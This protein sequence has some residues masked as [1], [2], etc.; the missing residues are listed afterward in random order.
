MFR[1][2]RERSLLGYV[3]LRLAAAV[4]VLFALLLAVALVVGMQFERHV[5]LSAGGVPPAELGG[6]GPPAGLAWRDLLK[7]VAALLALAAFAILLF[8]TFEN[9]RSITQ[10]FERVKHLMRNV[11][12][13][14]PTGVLTLDPRGTVTSLNSAAERLLGVRASAVVG[15]PVD[16]VLRA[17]PE[18][19]AWIRTALG[20]HG[21]VQESDLSLTGDGSRRMTLRLSASELRDESAR[22]DGLVVLIRDITEV[23]RLELQLRRADKLAALG[24]LAAGVAHEVKNPLHALS[25]N[26]HLL[27]Q[28]LEAPQPSKPE[29]KVYLDILRSEIQRI[30]RIVENFLRF[31]KPSIPEIKPLDLNALAERVLSLVA[32]EAADHGVTIETEFDPAL[33]SVPA[34]EG[35]LAQVVLNLVINGLQAMPSGGVLTL[36]TR[37]QK[38]WAELTVRDSGGGIRPE[39]LPQI[40]DPY[41]T[42]RPGGVGLGLAIAH[43]IIEGHSGTI[44][45]ESK[46]GEGTVIIV[47]LPLAGV[48]AREVG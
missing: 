48:G 22:S 26:L 30:H 38:E 36:A 4:F 42:T 25:L 45:V 18:V 31:A 23:S 14:I 11:L 47:R 24:T 29:L 16:E 6:Q 27:A 37:R 2:A 46:A 10:T 20:G 15:R 7:V 17:A 41:F 8:T 40:F 34:D 28:E 3:P 35:Q 19:G 5:L 9:Y 21:L 32:F 39:L 44:D 33:D 12:Q 43:R 1:P 13:S